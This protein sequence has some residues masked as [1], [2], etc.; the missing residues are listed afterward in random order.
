MA[1][2]IVGSPP[3]LAAGTRDWAVTRPELAHKKPRAHRT[4][5]TQLIA[6]RIFIVSS[7]FPSAGSAEWI[8]S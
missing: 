6:I 2:F 5:S 8:T 7:T 1:P 3:L 4:S